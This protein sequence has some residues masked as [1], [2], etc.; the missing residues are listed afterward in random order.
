MRMDQIRVGQIVCNTR[1]C[2]GFSLSTQFYEVLKIN[3]VTVTVKTEQ[4]DIIRMRPCFFDH[5][6]HFVTKLADV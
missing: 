3:R 5:E 1:T 2:D 6:A 4:N